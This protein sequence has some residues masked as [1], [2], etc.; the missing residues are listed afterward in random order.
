MA[1]TARP[2]RSA[3][4]LPGNKARALEKATTLPADA[5]IF[6]L[7]D[8]VGPDAKAESRTRACEA[9]ATGGYGSRELVLRI[10]G[11]D[12]E[13]HDDDLAAAAASGAHGVLVPK[14]ERAAQVHALAAALDALG[15]PGP[16]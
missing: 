7:E 13:W 2:R 4:Y 6:D 16:L 8:A 14:V 9:I 10:N 3:L 15:A 12:T 1:P 5:L 11:L